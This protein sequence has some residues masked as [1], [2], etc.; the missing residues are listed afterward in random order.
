M[1]IV[2]Y[3]LTGIGIVMLFLIY[4]YIYIMIA[5]KKKKS[6]ILSPL[7]ELIVESWKKEKCVMCGNPTAYTKKIPTIHRA[8]Y[9][10][11]AGQ[12][13]MNCNERIYPRSAAER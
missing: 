8:G 10:E 9:M 4:G 1:S 12:L 2:E 3:V 7:Y 5:G 6:G 11:G 13:C